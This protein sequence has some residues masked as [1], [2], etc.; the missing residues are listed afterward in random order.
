MRKQIRVVQESPKD[1]YSNFTRGME[2]NTHAKETSNPR[3]QLIKNM[4]IDSDGKLSVR[5]PIVPKQINNSHIHSA[6]SITRINRN[7]SPQQTFSRIFRAPFTNLTVQY[8]WLTHDV[9]NVSEKHLWYINN[10]GT[11]EE[12][13]SG[14]SLINNIDFDTDYTFI[15]GSEELLVNLGSEGYAKFTYRANTWSIKKAEEYQPTFNELTNSGPNLYLDNPFFIENIWESSSSN[16]VVVDSLLPF[17]VSNITVF[18]ELQGEFN[19]INFEYDTNPQISDQ[20][21]LKPLLQLHQNFIESELTTIFE[22]DASG[23]IVFKTLNSGTQIISWEQKLQELA[24]N[25]QDPTFNET[26]SNLLSAFPKWSWTVNN[27]RARPTGTNIQV[28]PLL[29]TALGSSSVL[30]EI[31]TVL[32]TIFNTTGFTLDGL[33][34]A[35]NI[36]VKSRIDLLKV[37]I[38]SSDALKYKLELDA[39][40]IVSLNSYKEVNIEPKE[41]RAGDP[42]KLASRD[43]ILFSYGPPSIN[44]A[45]PHAFGV[46]EHDSTADVK[47]VSITTTASGTITNDLRIHARIGTGNDY[48]GTPHNGTIFP[49]TIKIGNGGTN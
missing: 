43:H 19:P 38:G 44:S 49:G 14:E 34:N 22:K 28:M 46:L 2:Y 30:K 7:F 27:D 4:E 12:V 31:D 35:I 9:S 11:V 37:P 15:T 32:N 17:K 21:Y 33:F 26:D 48:Y 3:V 36:P 18:N 20:I 40:G 23:G 24:D 16:S 25:L 6:F 45:T 42:T 1:S 10:N 5:R 13:L 39:G 47:G 29:F 41:V 8:L